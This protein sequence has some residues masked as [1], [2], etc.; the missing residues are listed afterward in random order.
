LAAGIAGG[1]AV[2]GV[3]SWVGSFY[4]VRRFWNQYVDEFGRA[5]LPPRVIPDLA[6]WPDTGLHAAWLGHSTVLLK[7]DGFTILTDPVF[8][9]RAGLHFGPVTLGVK[10][11]VAPPLEVDRLPRIDLVLVSHAHMDHLDTASLRRLENKHTRLVMAPNTSDLIRARRYGGVTELP[12][13]ES[14]RVGP[15]SIRAVEV[16]HWGARMRTDTW[17]G[18]NGYLIDAGRYRVL[19][20]GD[21]A[22]TDRF[23]ELRSSRQIDLAL[24]P[25][26]AY[27]PWIRYHCT[28]EQAWRM[29]NDARAEFFVPIHHQT[30]HLSRE[31]FFE[32]IERIVSAAGSRP[33]RVAVREIGA[34]FHLG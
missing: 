20:A 1:A 8:S 16:N 10:R 18:Y 9:R 6:R 19:F 34:E 30:F 24:M 2:T 27:N 22:F 15:A 23:S 25:V 7:I 4:G 13:R 3:A 32:P 26:G 5:I 21:T 14:L 12:W 29:G 11:L 17:R 33:E 31:P 28:P